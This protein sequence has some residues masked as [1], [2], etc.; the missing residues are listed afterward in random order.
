MADVY[1][2]MAQGAVSCKY[3][4]NIK[5]IT[6]QTGCGYDGE[7]VAKE[8]LHEAMDMKTKIDGLKEVFK[9]D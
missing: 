1:V 8:L 3:K 2:C 6:K 4:R 9:H 5:P 7:C